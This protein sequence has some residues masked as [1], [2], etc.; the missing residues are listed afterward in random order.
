MIYDDHTVSGMKRPANVRILGKRFTVR[1]IPNSEG[2]EFEG[3]ACNGLSD[4]DGQ[5]ILILE[6]LPLETEQEK[7]LH[8]TLHMIEASMGMENDEE[9]VDRF[10]KGLLASLKDNPSLVRYLATKKRIA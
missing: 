3:E 2:I 6:G 1:W 5:E 8:E 10:T 9:V 4:F 7:V